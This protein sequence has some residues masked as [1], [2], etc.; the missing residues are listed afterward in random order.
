VVWSRTWKEYVA[1]AQDFRV[2]V[3]K[4]E[5]APLTAYDELSRYD[6]R[7]LTEI[8]VEYGKYPTWQLVRVL[9]GQLPE[10]TYPRG[11]SR[12]IDPADI[13]R[14]CGW[15]PAAIERATQESQSDLLLEQLGTIV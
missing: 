15:S 6:I 10:W 14:A 3:R 8:H 2:R 13:L 7:V 12:V 1:P 5:A 9:H 4:E 11:S